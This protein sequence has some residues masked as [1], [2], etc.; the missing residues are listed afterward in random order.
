[1]G[2]VE[3]VPACLPMG[4]CVSVGTPIEMFV[5]ISVCLSVLPMLVCGRDW[6]LVLLLL[7]HSQGIGCRATLDFLLQLQPKGVVVVLFMA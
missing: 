3:C 7:H 1:M 2:G 6:G 4:L 5:C